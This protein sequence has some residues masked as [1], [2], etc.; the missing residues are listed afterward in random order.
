MNSKMLEHLSG[1]PIASI[2]NA[3]SEKY[4]SNALKMMCILDYQLEN[5]GF[6]QDKE[7]VAMPKLMR[8]LLNVH[9][10]ASFK[11]IKYRNAAEVNDKVLKCKYC[12]LIGPYLVVL[13]LMVIN[14]DFHASAV[15]CMW[16]EKD[17]F[18]THNTSKSLDVCYSK[19]LEKLSSIHFPAVIVKFYDLLKRLAKALDMKTDRSRYFKNA[20]FDS[21]ETIPLDQTDDSMSSKIVVSMPRKRKYKDT[22]L[23]PMEKLYRKAMTYFYKDQAHDYIDSTLDVNSTSTTQSMFRSFSSSSSSNRKSNVSTQMNIGNDSTKFTMP[24]PFTRH[25]SPKTPSPFDVSSSSSQFVTPPPLALPDF[26]P[27]PLYGMPTQASCIGKSFLSALDNIP[28]EQ[29][30]KQATLEIRRIIKEFSAKDLA[31]QMNEDSHDSD[32]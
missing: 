29:M 20:M 32:D 13:E 14:H 23:R 8:Q 19:Y 4:N 1:R 26:Q 21:L 22:D 3:S 25:D 16:C 30:K 11:Y 7:I 27:L 18:E 17:D 15:L 31:K 12:Q 9:S 24:F 28:D 10:F 6:Y 5:S 2:V